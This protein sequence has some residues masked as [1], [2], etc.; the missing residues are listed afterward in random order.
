MCVPPAAAVLRVPAGSL[1]GLLQRLERLQRF[2]A[3]GQVATLA[4]RLKS[5]AR[6]VSETLLSLTAAQFGIYSE[7]RLYLA[8]L[9]VLTVLTVSAVPIVPCL[10]N[11]SSVLSTHRTQ[12]H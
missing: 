2:G 1:H 6:T 12:P 11:S 3:G 9:T 10:T 5:D 7:Y 8:V 4:Q